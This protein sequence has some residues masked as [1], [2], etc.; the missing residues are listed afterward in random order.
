MFYDRNP[1]PAQR[2]GVLNMTAALVPFIMR[3]PEI[4]SN[5]EQFV[6]HHVTNEFSAPEPYLRA[7]VGFGFL[8]QM[9]LTAHVYID[10]HV[11]SSALLRRL[12]SSGLMTR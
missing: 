6:L 1:P 12:V 10:R 2:F 9:I 5:M 4:K 8:L 3:H 11:R 7:I